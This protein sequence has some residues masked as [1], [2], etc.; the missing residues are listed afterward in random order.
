LRMIFATDEGENEETEEGEGEGEGGLSLDEDR[1]GAGGSSSK[2]PKSAPATGSSE[3]VK[4]AVAPTAASSVA[5]KMW[6]CD[7]CCV[8]NPWEQAKC[9]ARESAV[10]H[11]AQLAPALAPVTATGGS[12]S[13]LG[14]TFGSPAAAVASGTGSFTFGAPESAAAPGATPFAGGFS[15]AAAAP[16]ASPT[17]TGGFAFGVPAPAPAN[18]ASLA[19]AEAEADGE[20]NAGSPAPSGAPKTSSALLMA[21]AYLTALELAVDQEEDMVDEI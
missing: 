8:P 18:A 11:T 3:G 5:G 16:V 19:K 14:F 7:K 13:S 17:T 2:A 10:P 12:I 15:F 1:A 9:L 4:W 6:K 20:T 21:K